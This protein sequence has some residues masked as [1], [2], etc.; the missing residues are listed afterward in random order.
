[1]SKQN[2]MN[3]KLYN[4]L[5]STNKTHINNTQKVG[6][7]ESLNIQKA[8]ISKNNLTTISETKQLTLFDLIN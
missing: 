7:S 4:S 1:M 2:G 5:S 3:S 6:G 8:K